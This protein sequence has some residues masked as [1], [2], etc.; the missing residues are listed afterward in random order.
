MKASVPKSKRPLPKGKKIG[1][2]SKP[3]GELA[4]DRLPFV[5]NDHAPHSSWDVPMSGGFFGGCE[6]G[7]SVAQLFLKYVRD[8]QSYPCRL[9]STLLESMFIGLA[10]KQPET[11]DEVDSVTGQRIG[12][13]GELARWLEAATTQLGASL[14]RISE[15]QLVDMANH[16]LT[17]TDASL[18]AAIKAMEAP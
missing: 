9:S 17:R 6:A 10:S 7:K 14:D 11:Q 4:M 13:I 12:F 1:L 3:S 2:R 5:G 18:V 15:Q 8:E 16:H